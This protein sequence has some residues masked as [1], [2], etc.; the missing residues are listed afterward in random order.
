MS[1][2]GPASDMSD[3]YEIYDSSDKRF[4]SDMPDEG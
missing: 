3:L 1:T 2:A 4:L